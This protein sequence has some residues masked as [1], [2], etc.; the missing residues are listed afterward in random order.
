[1]ASTH[2]AQIAAFTPEYKTISARAQQ[3]VAGFPPL[4]R[5][6]AT[7]LLPRLE[8]GT[9]SPIVALLPLWVAD[10]L[11]DLEPPWPAS[12]PDE[13]ETL[14]L[15]NLLGWWSYLLQDWLLDRDVDRVDLLPLSTALS[16]A[17]VRL[18]Q[19]LLPGHDAFW[20]TFEALSL[21]AAE[22]HCWEQRRR[23]QRPADLDEAFLAGTPDADL[24]RLADRAALLQLSTAAQFALRGHGGGSGVHRGH[25][26]YTAL[27]EML[28]HYAVARQIGDDLDDWAADLQAGRLTYV[29]ARIMRRMKETGIVQSYGE[30]DVDWVAHYFLYDDLLLTDLYA[31]ALDA[32]GRAAE[33]IAPYQPLY[34]GT[35]MDEQR[36]RLESGCQAVLA[37]R[38]KLRETFV[39][40]GL[41]KTR[42]LPT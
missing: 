36:N 13:T 12:S 1:M 10:L 42:N 8:Q 25:P 22:A 5:E 2:G 18:Y 33:A 35:L 20:K 17:A 21:V 26:L 24:E 40:L 38:D 41:E 14:G 3:V 34:L 15:A 31:V 4:L 39:P 7:P 11:D 9:F 29:S 27:V 37:G 30:L 16:A 6:L 19:G 23:F 32:C 28:R